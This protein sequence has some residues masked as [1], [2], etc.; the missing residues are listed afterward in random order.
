MFAEKAGLYTNMRA[1]V[2]DGRGGLIGVGDVSRVSVGR[3]GSL[4]SRGP[5]RFSPLA[6]SPDG[7]SM[8]RWLGRAS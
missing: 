7:A 6:G 5:L 4:R 1:L 8:P 3:P 2:Q